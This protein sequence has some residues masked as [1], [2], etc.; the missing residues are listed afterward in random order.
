M[1]I[2]GQISA[3]VGDMGNVN[4]PFLT[5]F[6][7]VNITPFEFILIVTV[8]LIETILILSMFISSIES[9]DDPIGRQ[10]ITGQSLVIGFIVFAVC[11]F[12]TLL[13]F[14]PMISGVVG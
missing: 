8:Y 1:K 14:E 5:Q 11:M 3:K 2:L 10:S 13:M 4:V 12:G 7:Q 9:G 6:G